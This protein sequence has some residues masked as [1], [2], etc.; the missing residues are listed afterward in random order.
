MHPELLDELLPQFLKEITIEFNKLLSSFN[1]G[2]HEKVME[3]AHKIRGTAQVF[4]AF[5]IEENAER[6]EKILA[7][8]KR[9]SL[10]QSIEDLRNNIKKINQEI[11]TGT[12]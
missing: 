2:N 4:G 9:D 6:I 11:E 5:E 1:I 3:V 8:N 10:L 7:G 12:K